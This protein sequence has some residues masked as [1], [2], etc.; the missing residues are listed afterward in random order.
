MK[1][2]HNIAAQLANISLKKNE[3]NLALSLERLSSGYKITKAADDSAG[4]AISNKMRTQIRALDQASRNAADGSSVLETA[5]GALGEIQSVL[6]RIR[7]LSVQASNDTNTISDRKA[8]QD[9]IEQLLDEVDRIAST[10]EFN[11][12]YLLD[13]SSSRTMISSSD[14]VTAQSVSMDVLAGN[15]T[16]EIE[17]AATQATVSMDELG[18][19]VPAESDY[20]ITISGINFEVSTSDTG[21]DI[22]DRLVELCDS[23]NVNV[24]GTVEGGDFKMTA[25][26]PGYSHVISVKA[27]GS[28]ETVTYRGTD[29][30]ISLGDTFNNTASYSA[31]GNKITIIDN[32]GMEIRCEISTSVGE[33]INGNEIT[34]SVYNAGYMT[35][36]I[37]ANEHQV[38]N[39]NM[40]ETSCS[41]LGLRSEDGVSLIN[42]CTTAGA[43]R[44]IIDVDNAITR[45]SSIRSQIGAYE[46]RLDTAGSSLDISSENMTDSM[47]RIKDTDMASEMTRY[48]Q[49]QVLEQAATSMLSQANN[50]PE[51]VMSLLGGM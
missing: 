5:D 3:S 41:S 7:Q 6:Q 29:A 17:S 22:Q 26:A 15:Y 30:V 35:I 20:S 31:D 2:N 12:K 39:M 16:F 43:E 40:P 46:N 45:V 34:M 28:D 47:S 18:L 37:G 19:T 23:I 50:L 24:S 13:G 32:D 21:A 38:L 25:N 48:T 27:A 42:V 9:E 11:G 1:I 14:Y 8:M 4:M 36:Q 10:T 44:A 49:Y 33:E 51:T